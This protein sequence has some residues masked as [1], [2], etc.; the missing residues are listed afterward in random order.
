MSLF[1]KKMNHQAVDDSC[2]HHLDVMR[3]NYSENPIKSRIM[4]R[5][6]WLNRKDELNV[7]FRDKNIIF[8]NGQVYYAFLVQAN[9]MLFDSKNKLD[10]PALI[11]Y[12]THPIAEEYPEFLMGLGSEIYSYKGMLEEDVPEPLRKAVREVSDEYSRSG[13]DFSISITDP[14]DPDKLIDDVDVHMCTVLIFRRDLPTHVLHGGFLPILAAPELSPAVLILPK[15]Y[16]TAP[17][18][19]L[20]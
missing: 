19:N 18:Y 10:L 20:T 4:S 11:M 16:W 13:L 14:E 17:F 3:A 15:K 7:V 2:K 6:L 12:S 1:K 9:E 5:P 8:R